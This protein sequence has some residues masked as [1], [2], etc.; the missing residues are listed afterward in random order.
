MRN[1]L[2]LSTLWTGLSASFVVLSDITDEQKSLLE[3]LPP[4][5]RQS[6]EDK[7]SQSNRIAEEIDEAF[8]EESGLIQRPELLDLSDCTDC[9]FGYDYFKQSP[10]TFAQINNSPA[11]IN[12]ILGPGDKLKL[13]FYGTDSSEYSSY[14]SRDGS[15]VVPNLGPI[16]FAGLN[17]SEAKELI[18]EKVSQELIGIEATLSI[19]ELRSLTVYMT[20]EAYRPGRY[21]LSGLSSVTNALFASG[22]VSQKGSLRNI[23][24]RRG[25]DLIATY[26]FYD[27]L[28][29]GSTSSDVPLQNGDVIFIP[30][31][32]NKVSL[33][34]SFK[35]PHIYEFKKGETIGD[36][37]TMAGGYNSDVIVNS[38]IEHSYIN[39]EEGLREVSSFNL[40]TLNLKTFLRNGDAINISSK[41]GL[42]SQT[43]T[44]SG[45]VNFPGEYSL[46]Q[47]DK[48]LDIIDRAGGLTNESYIQGAV[49]TRASVADLQKKS[50]QKTAEQLESSL[51]N[52][53]ALGEIEPN[54]YSLTPI[55]RLIERLRQEEPLGRQVV[56]LNYL[57]LKTNPI[58]NFLVQGEDALFIPKR[59]SSV[60]VVGEVLNSITLSFDPNVTLSEYLELAGGLTEIA[61]KDKIFIIYPNGEAK[62]LSRS[63][64]G[65]GNEVLPGSTI[66][67]SRNAKPWDAIRLT[68]IV[69]PILADLA[70]S[71]AA[72]AAISDN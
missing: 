33:G 55:T 50:F 58:S 41:S 61:D 13:S 24:I 2:L 18:E 19:A 14:I 17:F 42:I 49:F 15:I 38:S 72:I 43:F 65:R 45:E 52:A 30:F 26:D 11:P 32:E 60:S 27:F 36:A 34:G 12:Y 69:T 23:E 4:D 59:P 22:G 57:E 20:G 66:V 46:S 48:I 7:M 1:L 28:L 40:D 62:V 64:F 5:Q 10:S 25:N 68:Q 56:K 9:I 35:R 29:K 54:E 53:I 16:Y 31:I 67:V 37:I 3:A 8:E 44:I 39:R 47:G 63:L 6:V 51:V 21:T 71:A 70:T